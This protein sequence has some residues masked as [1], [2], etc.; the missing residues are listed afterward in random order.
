M[1]NWTITNTPNYLLIYNTEDKTG[2]Y[3]LKETTKVSAENGYLIVKNGNIEVLRSA[4][5]D[6]TSQISSPSSTDLLD[7]LTTVHG[8]LQ[9]NI[10]NQFSGG[11]ADYNDFATTVTPITITGGAGLTTLTND[12]LGVYTNETKLPFGVTKLWDASTSKLDLTGM[13]VG[14]VIDMRITIQVV[15]ATNNTEISGSL[16]LG[17][18]A[19]TFEVPF[20]NAINYKT[21][22]T[23]DLSKYVGFYIGS[24][25]VLDN[26]GYIKIQSDTTCTVIVGGWYIKAIN[27]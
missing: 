27:I 13:S 2:S 23:Y 6:S 1:A 16:V 15:V 19:S 21:T 3:H 7:L 10:V 22:G 12:T 18:G 26:G 14:D 17:S 9:D 24:E 25:D 5:K 8:Y 4:W 11:W 20:L